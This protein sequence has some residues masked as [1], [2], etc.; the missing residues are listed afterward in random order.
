[1]LIDGYVGAAVEFEGRQWTI[2]ETQTT[3][4]HPVPHKRG[5]R[6][7]LCPVEY[8]ARTNEPAWLWVSVAE[9]LD[10]QNES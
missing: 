7:L 1:M 2:K 9:V 6:V 5:R 3:D 8:D 10:G 4:Q